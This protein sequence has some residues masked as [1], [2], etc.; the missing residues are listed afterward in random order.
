MGSSHFPEIPCALCGKPVDLQG[1][2]CADEN[3]Q[4]VHED[5]YA[6]RVMRPPIHPPATMM[7]D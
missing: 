1:D 3:G 7:S 4:A 5:C 6:K 2:L